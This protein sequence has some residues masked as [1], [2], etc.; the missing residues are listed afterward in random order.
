MAIT[1]AEVAVVQSSQAAPTE[2][3]IAPEA[4]PEPTPPS[5]EAGPEPE[6]K[7][8]D[9]PQID[10]SSRFAALTRKER[11]IVERE[12]QLKQFQN[13]PTWKEYQQ[14]RE[15][16]ANPRQNAIKLVESMG[17]PLKDFY[18]DLTGTILN[19]GK[20]SV[21][22]E[23]K[24]I[25]DELARERQE[26][27]DGKKKQEQADNDRFINQYKADIVGA[28]EKQADDFELMNLNKESGS[29]DLALEVAIEH[30]RVHKEIPTHV[31]VCKAVESYLETES[32]KLLSAKKFAVK[33]EV[34]QTEK[35]SEPQTG[36]AAAKTAP[37]IAQP[38]TLTNSNSA[39]ATP[40]AQQ[41]PPMSREDRLK[42]SAQKLRQAWEKHGK[43]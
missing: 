25:K 40:T 11:A 15:L 3:T 30:F 27:L 37:V 9:K 35:P 10:F 13:D 17:V 7:E 4:T 39:A 36:A 24:A 26:K 18:E 8:D 31:E 16:K 29:I 1:G 32:K 28:I 2:S 12:R 34:P 6:E 19:D 22:L 14:F 33:T 42:W 20:P 21:E 23:L 5:A 38:K 41:N 43:V